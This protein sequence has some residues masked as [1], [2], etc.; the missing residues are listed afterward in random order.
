MTSLGAEILVVQFMPTSK[1]HHKADSLLPFPDDQR[2]FLQMSFI[3]DV[4]GE[5]I[6]HWNF[7]QYKK[8][9]HFPTA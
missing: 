3:G 5:L 1:V 8:I 2:K 7:Y 4:N 9:H 6:A